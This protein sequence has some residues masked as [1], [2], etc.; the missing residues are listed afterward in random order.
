MRLQVVNESFQNYQQGC[1]CDQLIENGK[2]RRHVF[3]SFVL[4]ATPRAG[5]CKNLRSP[6][7]D[8][9][10][11]IPP[12]FVAWRAGTSSRVVVPSRT[13]WFTGTGSVN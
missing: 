8:S 5:F 6:G 1:V 2:Q 9:K 10:E 12:A 11:V 7:I 3:L 4:F 13:G